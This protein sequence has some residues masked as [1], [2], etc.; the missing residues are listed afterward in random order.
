MLLAL[1]SLALIHLALA[2]AAPARII[3]GNYSDYL[4]AAQNSCRVNRLGDSLG[5]GA[6]L[7][8]VLRE[9]A[10]LDASAESRLFR[11]WKN[12]H[13]S[14]SCTISLTLQLYLFTYLLCDP[15]CY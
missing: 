11:V 15:I 8:G 10:R 14:I 3:H 2:V 13:V 12:H 9:A 5:L 1:I 7:S 6:L 4:S